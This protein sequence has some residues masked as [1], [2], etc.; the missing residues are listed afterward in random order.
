MKSIALILGSFLLVCCASTPRVHYY[1]FSKTDLQ[2]TD[3]GKAGR[4]SVG[5][6]KIELAEDIDI[7]SL[8]LEKSDRSMHTA[9]YHRWQHSLVDSIRR[10]LT[11]E[12][13]E[14]GPEFHFE[15]HSA[16]SNSWQLTIQLKFDAFYGTEDGRSIVSGFWKLMDNESDRETQKESFKIDSEIQRDGYAGLVETQASQLTRL[17]S[18]LAEAI[19]QNQAEQNL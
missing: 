14:A 3:T 2:K 15:S 10:H 5:I 16:T 7:R 18:D 4:I 12:L 8:M 19:H 6:A 1:E 13:A 17:A 9:E 11:T